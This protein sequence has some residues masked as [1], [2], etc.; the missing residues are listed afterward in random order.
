MGMEIWPLGVASIWV[1]SPMRRREGG[2]MMREEEKVI[3]LEV[4]EYRALRLAK[5]GT[6]P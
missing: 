6:R 5:N 4:V 3:P 1:F 2:V